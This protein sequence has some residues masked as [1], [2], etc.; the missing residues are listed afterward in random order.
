M[1]RHLPGAGGRRLRRPRLGMRPLGN[2]PSPSLSLAIAS[3][4]LAGVGQTLPLPMAVHCRTMVGRLGGGPLSGPVGPGR[5]RASPLAPSDGGVNPLFG[6][7]ARG[8]PPPWARS[9]CPAAARRIVGWRAAVAGFCFL[10]LACWWCLVFFRLLACW[11]AALVLRVLFLGER[12]I[13]M[14]CRFIRLVRR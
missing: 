4:F 8:Y 6:R 10:L 1:G 11:R 7:R 2:F 3:H 12:E 5:G 14:I 13:A 9:F